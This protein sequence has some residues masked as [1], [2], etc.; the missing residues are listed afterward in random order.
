MNIETLAVILLLSLVVAIFARL[1]SGWTLAGF[2]F[3][4]LLACAGGIGG[5]L[6]QRRLGLPAIYDLR[7]PGSVTSV[8]IIWPGFMALIAAFASGFIWRPAR[9]RR[10]TRR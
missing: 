6:L 7:L 1:V 3:S 2:L 5:W 9:P 10:R 4:Y 8:P